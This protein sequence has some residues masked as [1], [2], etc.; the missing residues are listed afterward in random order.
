[1]LEASYKRRRDQERKLR[2]REEIEVRQFCHSSW[3][4]VLLFGELYI[5]Q[6]NDAGQ[7]TQELID[8]VLVKAIVAKCGKD[9]C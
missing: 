5:P 7:C 1:M 3:A 4:Y 6:V 8:F 2:R 9:L